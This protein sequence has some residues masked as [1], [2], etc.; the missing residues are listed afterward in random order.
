MINPEFTYN[1]TV[2]NVVDGDT[3]D[4]RIDVGFDIFHNIRIRLYG[5]NAAE[6]H[7]KIEAE[8][9]KAIAAENR[10]RELCLGKG[11][12]IKTYKD[13]TEKFGRYLADVFIGER[14][15][16]QTLVIENLAVAYFGGKRV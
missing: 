5:I 6:K 2:I 13:K 10:V 16:N 14:N 15:V 8:K 11:V 7:S 9:L 4:V 12:V 3:L 1:A